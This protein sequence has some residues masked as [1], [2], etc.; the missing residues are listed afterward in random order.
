MKF[1][2]AT[3]ALALVIGFAAFGQAQAQAEMSRDDIKEIVKEYLLENPEI[4]LQS[5]ND[6]QTKGVSEAQEKALTENQRKIFDDEMTPVVGNPDGDVRVV[7]FFD[8]NCG[9]CKRVVGDV[10][11]LV[12]N[13]DEVK[14]ILKEF[15]ILGP[16]S[17]TA[18]RWALA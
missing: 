18:A 3:A 8:Y 16:T 15:P 13:D 14:L 4:I 12:E 2:L 5:V 17:E 9:Y 10:N 7:E 11:K 1:K 6:Y